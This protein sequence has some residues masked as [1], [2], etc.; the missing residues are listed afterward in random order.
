MT[1]ISALGSPLPGTVLPATEAPGSTAWRVLMTLAVVFVLLA[2]TGWTAV[3]RHDEASGPFAAALQSW[4]KGG[5]AGRP[6]PEADAPPRTIARFFES[7]S[8]GQRDRL[9]ARHPLIVGNLGGAPVELRYR[10]NHAALAEAREVERK[11]MHNPELTEAGREEAGSRMDR[12]TSMLGEGRRFLAFDPTGHGRA[13]EVFGDLRRAERVSVV[14]PGNDS[15][16]LNFEREDDRTYAAPAGMARALQ[17]QQHVVAPG[18][19]SATIAWADYSAP[20]G[21]GMDSASVSMAKE[22]AERLVDL[23]RALPGGSDV[24][25]LCHSYGSVVCGV[26]A[27]ELPGRVG[28]IA[29]AG[30]PGMRADSVAELDTPARV[31]A[32]RDAED[33]IADVPHME[34]AGLGHG[35]DPVAAGFGAR[36][37]SAR[38]ASGHAGYFVPGTDSLANLASVAAGHPASV[39]CAE[40]GEDCT[41]H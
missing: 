31:W 10:A 14:V 9:A 21:L 8:A 5:V 40:N 16:L 20:K 32:M 39:T 38:E 28:D 4:D 34:F 36:R 17:A 13:A 35:A 19:R 6:L 25:L 33:W 37:L 11:R 24:S 29:V 7:L 2:T 22:G 26:A 30:S 12:F 27:D 1:S 15:D 23:V 41:A 18:T 3:K